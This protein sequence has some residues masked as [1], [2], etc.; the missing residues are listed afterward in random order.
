MIILIEITKNF[1]NI[2][3]KY[4]LY[5]YILISFIFLQIYLN[6]YFDLLTFIFYCL[7]IIIFDSSSYFFGA[8]FGQ[9]K[10]MKKISPN[11]TYVGLNF[12]IIVT[13]I[14]A[15]YINY[16]FNI[17]NMFECVLFIV[18]VIFLSFFGDILQSYFKRQSNIK[19]SSNIIPGHGG[20]FDRFDSFTLS[21]L[22]Y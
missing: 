13:L 21:N 5:V 8:F 6:Y 20:F 22:V 16:I 18:M 7:I 14:S 9:K 3:N 15:I 19:N 1:L 11:K 2:K 12:G 4:L 10:L 17:M